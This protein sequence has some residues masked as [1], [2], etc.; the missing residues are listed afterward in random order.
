M[1]KQHIL[2]I[3]LLL[4]SLVPAGTA[5]DEGQYYPMDGIRI[6]PQNEPIENNPDDTT[7]LVEKTGLISIKDALHRTFITTYLVE[8]TGLFSIK[9]VLHRTFITT[10]NQIFGFPPVIITELGSLFF[11]LL[12]GGALTGLIIRRTQ[13]PHANPRTQTIYSLIQKKPGIPDTPAD[14]STTVLPD[15]SLQ[16]G[17]KKFRSKKQTTT[18]TSRTK[19]TD[20]LS[21]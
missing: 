19:R 6:T 17:S 12:G 2:I 9:D 14:P 13:K 8:K 18:T 5:A 4:L 15:S 16:T 21:S 10:Y 11:L 1:N 20:H 3:P 7:P